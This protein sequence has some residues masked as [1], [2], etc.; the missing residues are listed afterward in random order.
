M[1]IIGLIGFSGV[2]AYAQKIDPDADVNI[3]MKSPVVVDGKSEEWHEPLNNFNSDTKLAFALGN[4]EKNLYLIIE[5]LDEFTTGKL[6]RAGL[7]LNINT[8][9]KK[10]DGIKLDFL[11]MREQPPQPKGQLKDSVA[12]V[13]DAN[14]AAHV[15]G[16]KVISVTG[17]KNIP[18]GVLLMP[19]DFGIQVAAA[20]NQRRDYICELA[21][22]LAQLNLTGKEVKGIAYQI[23]I[24][25]PGTSTHGHEGGE[26][27]EGMSRGPGMGGGRGGR[28]GGGGM[29]AGGG[30]KG[31]GAGMSARSSE[32][33]GGN[34]KPDFWI[35]YN[36][37]TPS[38]EAQ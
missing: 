7:T 18:D 30:R 22:P 24:N 38:I 21:I 37:A 4:D 19:N 33:N 35:K 28:G 13:H 17:F 6:I 25:S 1:I 11:G 20:F 15:P 29:G 36:L 16:V 8:A 32:G 2:S 5:S 12:H 23:K 3:W 31:A 34:S 9:G 10:K 14:S 27:G 26:K